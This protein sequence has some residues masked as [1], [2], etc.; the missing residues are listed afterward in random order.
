MS[1]TGVSMYRPTAKR[2]WWFCGILTLQAFITIALE[3]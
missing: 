3:A 2:E 1:Q